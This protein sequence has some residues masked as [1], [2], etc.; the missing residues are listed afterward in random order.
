M[1]L[2]SS[3]KVMKFGFEILALVI[4]ESPVKDEIYLVV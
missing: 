1:L 4:K 3:K 2:D